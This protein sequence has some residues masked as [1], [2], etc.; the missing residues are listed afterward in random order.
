MSLSLNRQSGGVVD[1]DRVMSFALWCEIN[2]L[3]Q[4]TG[5][6]LRKAGKGPIFTQLSDRRVGVTVRNN[7]IWQAARAKTEADYA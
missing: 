5:R 3:S 4:A 6:R 1:D 7:R 2:S